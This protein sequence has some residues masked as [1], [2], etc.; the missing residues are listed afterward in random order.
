MI[1]DGVKT[2]YT[3]QGVVGIDYEGKKEPALF[4]TWNGKEPIYLFDENENVIGL[5]TIDSKEHYQGVPQ[6]SAKDKKKLKRKR[7]LVKRARK[8][9]R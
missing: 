5:N 8:R 2:G 3:F 1:E 7:H 4:H 9:N 6:I